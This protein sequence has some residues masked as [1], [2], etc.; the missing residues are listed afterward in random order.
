M[1]KDKYLRIERST[2]QLCHSDGFPF[3]SFLSPEKHKIGLTLS[4]LFK[5][6]LPSAH[7]PCLL[8]CF[9]LL[10][11]FRAWNWGESRTQTSFHRSPTP[12]WHSFQE[13]FVYLA[14]VSDTVLCLLLKKKNNKKRFL[15]IKQCVL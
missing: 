8:R 3:T 15:Q 5:A 6:I 13:G 7:F 4:T 12:L 2:S 10:G 9:S 14:L 11:L 1:L